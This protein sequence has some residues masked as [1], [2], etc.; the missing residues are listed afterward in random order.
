MYPH[1][2]QK[3]CGFPSQ[4]RLVPIR[5]RGGHIVYVQFFFR[6]FSVGVPLHMLL[7]S[8]LEGGHLIGI[9]HALSLAFLHG[10]VYL[11]NLV[12]PDFAEFFLCM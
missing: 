10:M 3:C 7:E 4:P 1:A 12:Y 2:F 6:S 9:W 5:G 8:I 11:S